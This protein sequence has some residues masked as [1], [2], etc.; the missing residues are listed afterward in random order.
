MKKYSIITAILL[1]GLALA[2]CS[3]K[4]KQDPSFKEFAWGKDA[5]VQLTA[6]QH[7]QVADSFL[8]QGKPEM[9]FVHFNK[10]LEM[11]P[12]NM[13]VRVKK[14]NLLV[15][16]GLDEQALAEYL[17]VLKQQPDHAI[18]NEA[19][20]TVYF[21]AGLY[22]EARTHLT[23]AVENNPM[24]WKAQN[25][26][27]NLFDREGQYAEAEG[28]FQ[29]ALDLH[30]G[31]HKDEI[32]NNMGVVQ[33]ALKQYGKAVNSF[34]Y[35]LKSGGVSSRTYN[36]LGLALTRQGRLDEALEAFK[37]AGGEFKANNN[38]GYVL[39]TDGR[40]DEAVPYF[41]RAV[42]LAPSFYVK[43]AENLKRARMAS[44]FIGKQPVPE[45]RTTQKSGSTPNPLLR[46]S[47]PDAEQ[48]PGEPAASPAS[49]GSPPSEAVQTIAW[50]PGS[51]DIITTK[52]WG[53][54]VSSWRDHDW[55]FRHCEKLVKQGYKPWINQVD[56]G[57]KGLWYR[58]LVGRY[59]SVDTAR[60]DRQQII[61][62][63]ELDR[64]PIYELVMPA[65]DGSHL[66]AG[67]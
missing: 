7:E 56:L 3:A 40:P 13:D 21:R 53:V 46:K 12:D 48:T 1:L 60:V 15:S 50:H 24:L 17:Y 64:A 22:T 26:L 51:G 29:R 34:R 2:G 5:P 37:Y 57:E 25:Y 30:K 10:A 38:L 28:H 43:A 54:H 49:A 6:D 41:E 58:V 52:T 33:I 36:N 27:G 62:A 31:P 65:L 42:E 4:S 14:G 32:Y 44:R 63:L 8:R 19:A 11:N 18:A 9:A 61:D 55:A 66:H 23:R 45:K 20:G 59:S 16:K 39:L 35:A 67:K 47:F